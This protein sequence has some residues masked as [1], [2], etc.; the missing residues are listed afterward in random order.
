[1][2]SICFGNFIR[3]CGATERLS[4]ALQNE[5]ANIATILL[6]LGVGT[7][8][9]AEKFLAPVTLAILGLGLLAFV[10]GTAGGVI[11]AK[12]MN[13]LSPH[14][15]VNPLIGSA[16]VSAFPM[17]ARVSHRLGQEADPTNF[18][19]FQAMGANVAGQVGSVAAAGVILALLG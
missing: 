19:I 5:I 13:W 16:G 3:E 17:A 8:M 15:P 12:I 14:N 18:L 2:G 11:F 7:Q 9:V 10:V 4:K 6:G 1:M